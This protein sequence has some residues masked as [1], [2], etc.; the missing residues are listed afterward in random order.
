MAYKIIVARP[1]YED[2]RKATS[3][4]RDTLQ[5]NQAAVRLRQDVRKVSQK[6]AEMPQM[7]GFCSD[8]YLR[9][10]G[11]RKAPVGRYLMIFRINEQRGEVHI[12]RFFH[13]SQDYE[14]YI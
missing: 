5:S 6:I 13:G 4:L 9:A 8:T 7:Y 3:Y 1:A 14:Q 11:F 2:L 12:L 10:K